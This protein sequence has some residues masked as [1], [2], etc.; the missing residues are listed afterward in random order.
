VEYVSIVLVRLVMS[1]SRSRYSSVRVV[2]PPIVAVGTV[3]VGNVADGV[4][5]AD[6][7]KPN[8]KSENQT[9]TQRDLEVRAAPIELEY[10]DRLQLNMITSRVCSHWNAIRVGVVGPS[11]NWRVGQR[12]L[13]QS[14]EPASA[15]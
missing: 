7:A 9:P 1:T 10:R 13:A 15:I 5:W 14:A 11:A 6:K 12:W 2:V 3:E 4:D 8:V